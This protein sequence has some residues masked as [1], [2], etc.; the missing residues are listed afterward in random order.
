MVLVGILFAA[1]VVMQNIVAPVQAYFLTWT[2]K[3][4]VLAFISIL[5][6]MLIGYGMHGMMRATP[7]EKDSDDYDF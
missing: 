6:G 3:T 5:I 7:D 4:F 1:V 2:T